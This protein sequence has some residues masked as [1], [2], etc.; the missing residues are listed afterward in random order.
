[1][2]PV[3][4][5]RHKRDVWFHGGNSFLAYDTEG[6]WRIIWTKPQRK[7]TS[8]RSSLLPADMPGEMVAR[9][10]LVALHFVVGRFYLADAM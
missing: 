10:F 5:G 1:M 9:R 6:I 3:A 2:F 4:E 7:L 8:H